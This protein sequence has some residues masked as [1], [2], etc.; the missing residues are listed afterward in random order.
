MNLKKAIETLQD[1]NT[2]LP[3]S[4]PEDRRKAV[5][6]GIEALKEVEEFRVWLGEFNPGPLPDETKD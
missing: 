5:Q 2:T 1:L 4:S 6:L 3:Q